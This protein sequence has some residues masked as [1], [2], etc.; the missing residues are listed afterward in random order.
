MVVTH[1]IDLAQ[2]VADRVAFLDGGRFRFIGTWAEADRS[3]DP[4]LAG[5]LARREEGQIE[6]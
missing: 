5:F 1:D 6:A 2:R 3:T 4:L